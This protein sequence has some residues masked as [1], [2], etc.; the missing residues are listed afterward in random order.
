MH[1][2]KRNITWN[3]L[4]SIL[5]LIVGFL[6]F[7]LI[8]SAYGLE[9]FGL[10]TLIWGLV[11][12]FS[13][14]DLGLSRALT[15][16]VSVLLTKEESA[17]EVSELI[18][19]GFALM[20]LLGGVGGIVLFFSAPYLVSQLL[21]VSSE[22]QQETI[23]S[24]ALIALSIPIVIHTSAMRGV[25]EAL[26]SFKII[27]II[28]TVLGVGAFVAPYLTSF[29]EVSLVFAVVGIIWVRLIVWGM[30]LLAV[31][32]SSVILKKSK[33]FE[34]IWLKPLLRFGG[35]MTVTNVIGPLMVYFDR[36]FIASVL[37]AVSVAY[38]AAPYEV[39]TK[40]WV[41]P[42]A[43]SGVLFPLFA[44]E[45]QRDTSRITAILD[46]GIRY[47]LL[48]IYPAGL[49]L[50]YFSTE[51]LSLW[52]GTDF[53]LQAKHVVVWLVSGVVVNSIAQIFFAQVQGGGNADWTAK[54][55][56]IELLPYL[57]LLWFLVDKWGISGVAF[58]WFVR[59]VFDFLG[60]LYLSRKM[61]PTQFHN[62][63]ESL[64]VILFSTLVLLFAAIQ[65][66]LSMRVLIF[67]GVL[68][69]YTAFFIKQLKKDHLFS[70]FRNLFESV[71]TN[72]K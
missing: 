69:L 17:K 14:F 12:Y 46:K 37:G 15:Q 26:H 51:W 19:T 6:L 56:L 68:L 34:P 36:F 23:T 31:Q 48:V 62:L 52:L 16:Q 64:K 60:L 18:R 8:I 25:L 7:P 11:G 24:F 30:Y 70:D 1:S 5:P 50:V 29:Y 32:N 22:L 67:S 3:L 54:L 27:S 33:R 43:I 49:V 58:A 4:G 20:W 65:L 9:R 66:S 28:R 2:A 45:W 13:L 53:S 47:T 71:Q 40:M 38:Y 61:N 55:H 59:V 44:K 21:K 41:I 42:A 39:V 10:L 63:N 35:W 57:L 72:E